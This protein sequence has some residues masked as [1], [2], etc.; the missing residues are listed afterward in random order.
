MS[1]TGSSSPHDPSVQEIL[2]ISP[3]RAC[4][5]WLSLPVFVD[6][7]SHICVNGVNGVT[8]LCLCVFVQYV[9]IVTVYSVHTT[10]VERLSLLEGGGG[11]LCSVALPEVSSLLSPVGGHIINLR[12]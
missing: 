6:F 5:P 10:S 8:G 2:H 1:Q 11:G 7:L 12:V 4:F 9:H 3:S